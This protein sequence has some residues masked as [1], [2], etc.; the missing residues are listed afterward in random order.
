MHT[1]WLTC[2]WR[3]ADELAN[4]TYG[5]F[6]EDRIFRS[7]TDLNWV[8]GRVLV[9]N[10]SDLPTALTFSKAYK[11]TPYN[12]ASASLPCHTLATPDIVPAF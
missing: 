8:I 6:T 7:P 2:C 12:P 11:V 1:Q 4:A 3:P 10:D 5:N 9:L